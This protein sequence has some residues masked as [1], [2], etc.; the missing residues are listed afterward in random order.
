VDN[1]NVYNYASTHIQQLE[2]SCVATSEIVPSLR[3]DT[4]ISIESSTLN[5]PTLDN[6][7][8]CQRPEMLN[9]LQLLNVMNETMKTLKCNI[10]DL[11]NNVNALKEE[12]A[13][14][15]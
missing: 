14:I 8:P 6:P 11:S 10:D 5:S 2:L 1:N 12:N 13:V 9:N 15:C 7:M 4:G 3:N